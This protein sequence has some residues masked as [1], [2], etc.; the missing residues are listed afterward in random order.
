[1]RLPII[2]ANWKM[3]MTT[4]EAKTFI[5]E[6]KEKVAETDV[7]VVI[8]PP[9]TLLKTLK[10]ITEGTNIKIGAQN[11]HW[12]EKGAYT[13][14]IS[15][16]M[17]KDLY[18]QY[19]VI[20]H[21]ERRK[22]FN[23]TDEIVNKKIKAALNHEIKP[24]L[25]IG[26]T[27]DERESNKQEEVVKNQLLCAL[28]GIDS[29]KIK[30]IVIAYEPIWAIGTGKTASSLDAGRMAEFIRETIREE[31]GLDI[32][33]EVRIQYGGSVKPNNISEIMNQFDIDGALVGGASLKV[34]DF[35]QIVR[36]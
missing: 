23:E 13:G 16:I 35:I 18:I 33:E 5:N 30:D 24:I 14:E 34:N 12:E 26:E 6:L 31:F 28:D 7:E 3:H 1:M 15:P 25:C 27:L 2:A 4:E 17:L 11:M 36:F 29:D 19:C 9:F 22:Y 32:S 10:E 20:G 21:S 8:C